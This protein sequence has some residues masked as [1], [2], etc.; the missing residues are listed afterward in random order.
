MAEETYYKVNLTDGTQVVVTS[1]RLTTPGGVYSIANIVSVSIEKT[2]ARQK[3][4]LGLVLDI[5]G[6]TV[7]LYNIVIN[8]NIVAL[9]T[10]DLDF[11]K[12]IVNAINKAIVS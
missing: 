2:T 10:Q 11:A 1:K 6:V 3:S 4:G 8:D 9:A 12:E 5:F 7:P